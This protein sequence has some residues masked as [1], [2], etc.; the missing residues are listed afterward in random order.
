MGCEYEVELLLNIPSL[1]YFTCMQH[2]IPRSHKHSLLTIGIVTRGR[3]DEL[4]NLLG[5]INRCE[6]SLTLQV[7]NN[8]E[9]I[10]IRE[11]V[12]EAL[13]PR[14]KLRYFW[15]KRN[16]GISGGRR[17]IVD[18]CKTKYL[19]QLDDDVRVDNIDQLVQSSISE[20][21]K[22]A[23][24]GAIAY[25]VVSPVDGKVRSCERPHDN[26]C[27]D[28]NHSGY[29]HKLI[30]ACLSLRVYSAQKVGNYSE[31]FRGWGFE[32]IDLARRMINQGFKIRYLPI[33]VTHLRSL[34]SRTSIQAQ[35]GT[36]FRNSAIHAAKHLK[37]RLAFQAVFLRGIR[38]VLLGRIL[39]KHLAESW[40]CALGVVLF[41]REPYG[42]TYY[43]NMRN[44]GARAW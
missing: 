24:V 6:H 42:D 33:S 31:E 9:E 41:S 19:L 10:D 34:K 17:L 3:V 16:L 40:F 4:I 26:P 27:F 44:L 21:E 14:H 43:R 7:L 36:L 1:V 15:P 18:E 12:T 39:L 20:F 28:L 30:G 37:I 32:E 22:L 11:K 35:N 38:N 8:C 2:R 5:D 13:N 29:T 23:D 25:R